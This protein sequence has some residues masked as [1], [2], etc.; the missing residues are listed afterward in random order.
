ML[1]LKYDQETECG[2]ALSNKHL[3]DSYFDFHPQE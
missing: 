2:I 3:V 1:L